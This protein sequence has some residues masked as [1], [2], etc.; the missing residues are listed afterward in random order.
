[1]R[2]TFDPDLNLVL[3]PFTWDAIT[4][5][6]LLVH[7]SS[8]LRQTHTA[9]EERELAKTAERELSCGAIHEGEDSWELSSS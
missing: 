1:M 9:H 6:R 8:E 7:Q 2:T 4:Q 5:S 3:I